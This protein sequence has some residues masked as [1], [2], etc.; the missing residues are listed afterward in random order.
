MDKVF[1][2]EAYHLTWF[3]RHKNQPSPPLAWSEFHRLR[4]DGQF[5]SWPLRYLPFGL[6]VYTIA[7]CFY[8]FWSFL[9]VL[10]WL[11][12]AGS[13]QLVVVVV[14]AAAAAEECL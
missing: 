11:T 10:S 13:K 4:A 7:P 5:S 12:P 9:L 2:K 8:L 6:A 14:V 3:K 1:C